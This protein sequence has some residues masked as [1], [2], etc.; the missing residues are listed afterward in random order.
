M[1]TNR[2]ILNVM[3][4]CGK[5]GLE[6]VFVQHAISFRDLGYKSLAVCP[7]KSPYVGQL[8]AAGI[9]TLTMGNRWWN[10]GAW[11]RWICILKQ[12]RPDVVCMHGNRAI[13][14]G[15]ARWVRLF[16]RS[17]PKLIATTHNVRNKRFKHLDGCFAITHVLEK[18][19]INDF[20]IPA[21]RVFYCPNAV[22]SPKVFEAR[23]YRTP[24]TIGFLRRLHPEKG[25]DIM[26]EA[27]RILKRKGVAF[28]LEMAGDGPLRA[29]YQ[30]F[31]KENQLE[32]EVTF[33]GWL[34]ENDKEDFFKRIDILCLPSRKE[35]LPIA[36]L[37]GLACAIPIVVSSHPGMMEVL[38]QAPCGIAFP[39]ED[40]AAL[41]EALK[42]MS[43]DPILWEYYS[44]A[45]RKVFE[46][47]Y[48]TDIQKLYLDKGIQTVCAL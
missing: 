38:E 13:S 30:K 27:C 44:L 41:A 2:V 26:L 39:M 25:G 19:L 35:G 5:G 40:V 11:I 34:G 46:E 42:K 15:I 22:P 21:S 36:L 17:L 23:K 33:C 37:E 18:S 7:P 6:S 20:E 9:E 28:R 16:V 48:S 32:K 8:H 12:C 4:G 29:Q 45:A 14:F 10:V 47:N 24:L 1:R 43:E 31:V 3:L